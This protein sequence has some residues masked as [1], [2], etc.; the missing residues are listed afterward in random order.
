MA[1]SCS[2]STNTRSAGVGATA[3]FI[4]I[5]YVL[6]QIER[7][8]I[9]DV[10]NFVQHM[11]YRR[12][13]M[14]QTSAQYIFI[15]DA[16]LESVLCGDTSIPASDLSDRLDA[17][18][19]LDPESQRIKIE[20]EFETLNHTSPMH[21]DFDCSI[22]ELPDNKKKN[23]SSVHLPRVSGDHQ[24]LQQLPCGFECRQHYE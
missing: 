23:R 2:G 11:R 19:E 24:Q 18:S 3:T 13:Y 22:A 16:I 21:T 8:A 14:V 7:E 1:S 12:N 20:V 9:V 10:F 17:L 15:H 6:K 5:D 4:C